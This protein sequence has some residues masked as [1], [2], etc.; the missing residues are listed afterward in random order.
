MADQEKITEALMT[1]DSKLQ[2]EEDHRET[3]ARLFR[4][5]LHDLMTA[6]IR[7]NDL[8]VPA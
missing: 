6:R 5:L 3:L 4:T 2:V 8:E 7:V 1:V